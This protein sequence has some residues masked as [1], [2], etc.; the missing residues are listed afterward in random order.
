M[1][2]NSFVRL[3]KKASRAMQKDGSVA[4]VK[5]LFKSHKR[6]KF[7]KSAN[8]DLEAFYSEENFNEVL[9]MLQNDVL[10]LDSAAF[11]LTNTEKLNRKFNKPVTSTVALEKSRTLNIWEIYEKLLSQEILNN[12]YPES[13]FT[14]SEMLKKFSLL[15][16]RA[17]NILAK[18]KI[19]MVDRCI[20]AEYNERMKELEDE[21]HEYE[22]LVLVLKK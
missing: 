10:V 6:K 14:D 17:L 7:L 16:Q 15:K 21:V 12:N 4:G 3:M 11:I 18:T 1:S 13:V 22:A 9:S 2:G 19:R 5:V 8:R 20:L